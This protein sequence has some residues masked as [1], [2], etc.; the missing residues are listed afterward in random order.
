[1]APRKMQPPTNRKELFELSRAILITAI[2]ARGAIP[3]GDEIRQV[4]REA[5]EF[6]GEI[7]SP[8]TR[9]PK[10]MRVPEQGPPAEFTDQDDMEW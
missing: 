3:T 10:V 7:D 1:M 5:R 2:G 4:V 9:R 6:L 8:T